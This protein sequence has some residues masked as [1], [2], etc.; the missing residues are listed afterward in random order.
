MANIYD[1]LENIRK[2]PHAYLFKHSII[3]LRTFLAGYGTAKLEQNI[4]LTE[5]DLEFDNFQQWIQEKYDVLSSKSWAII[6][7]ENS[8]DETE[9]LNNFFELFEE[10]R[11][12]SQKI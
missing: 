6:I 4:P 3:H 5:Q 8:Q 9:A 7:L 12:Q 10:F 2:R 1:L 11:K